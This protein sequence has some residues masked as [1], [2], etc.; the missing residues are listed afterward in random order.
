M[1][2]QRI[3][4]PRA[5]LFAAIISL[6][7][8]LPVIHGQQ[9]SRRQPASQEDDVLRIKTELV[10]TDL[11]VFDKHRRFVDGLRPEQFE[12]SVDGKPQPLSLFER[13]ISGSITEASQ[14]AATQPSPGKINDRTS[15]TVPAGLERHRVI[16]FFLD[17]LHLSESSLEHARTAL[18]EFVENQVG[19]NDR[20][21]IVSASGQIG[22][23]QQLSDNKAVLRAAIDRLNYKRNTET[24]AGRTVITEY[25]ANQIA[26]HGDK[27]LFNYI[28]SSTINEY[29]LVAPHGGDS[30]GLS[31][32]AV[33]IVANRTR[34]INAQSRAA[35]NNTLSVLL[36]LIRS[37][38]S[39]PGRKL[40]FLISDGFIADSRNSY[41]MDSLR[42]VGSV[43]AQTGIV[44]YTMD[45]RGTFSDPAVDAGRNDFPDGIA[46]G[47]SARMPSLESSAMR[48]PLRI[49]ADDTGGRAI[50]NS[51]SFTDAFQQAIDET[52]SYYL[53]AWRPENDE[54]RSGKARIK[55]GI[56]DRPD[57]RVRLRRNYYVAQPDN[58]HNGKD[59]KSSSAKATPETPEAAL[60]TTLGA[61]YPRRTIPTVLSVGYLS[62]ADQGLVLNASMQVDRSSLALMSEDA[63]KSEIDVMGA[64]IDDR[65]FIVTFKQLLTV[66]SDPSTQNQPVLWHQRLR[67]K[68][69]LYQVRIALRERSS[70][71]TG[72]A[73]QWIEVPDLSKGA[74]G[75]STL[76]L[77]ERKRE[78]AEAK[79]AISPQAIMVD[80]DHR[81]SRMSVMRFQTYIYNAAHSTTPPVI[82]I[83]VRVLSNNRAIMT[84]A[85]A[86]VPTDATKD[87]TRLP[88]WAELA[89]DSLPSGSYVL[90]VTAIDL[91]TKATA[92]QETNVIVE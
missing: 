33:S 11:M 78:A 55:V 18:A 59:E 20:V 36:S 50:L 89:L 86:R 92:T 49:L 76:F 83:Q 47:T 39:L 81:F 2:Q 58:S 31:Q 66:V 38:A 30:R 52:S 45:A 32:L 40:V 42:Q 68:P 80:V 60:L 69:G 27:D 63:R 61:L 15:L 87:L 56:K 74:L 22:F 70:G 64:A 43:A 75:M 91:T 77:G 4:G 67:L 84:L 24:Y 29:Q 79:P 14:L 37:S 17:D 44:V 28:V 51:N 34:Q 21:A 88:Y 54:Q 5:L 46:S 85:N 13:V 41:V 8:H 23:L 1:C 16:F 3:L 53:I 35:T 72:S 65:G 48:E 90:R 10:Q 82:E 7:V 12:L 57:L 62:T 25:E 6:G 26:D 73:Q 19:P 71:R 9:V